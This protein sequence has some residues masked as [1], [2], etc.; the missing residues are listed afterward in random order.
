MADAWCEDL[1]VPPGSL[2][3]ARLNGLRK[4]ALDE[5]SSWPGTTAMPAETLPYRRGE[6]E[7]GVEKPGKEAG[8]LTRTNLDDMKPMVRR[9]GTDIEFTPSF[10]TIFRLLWDLAPEDEGAHVMGALLFRMAFMLDHSS[11][12]PLIRFQ[13]SERAIEKLDL[14]IPPIEATAL[15]GALP[16]SVFL[17]LLEVLALNEDV[18]FRGHSG[19]GRGVGRRNNLLTCVNVI[20]W[21]LTG[22][23]PMVAGGRLVRGV[24][25]IP[26][27]A[28]REVFPCLRPA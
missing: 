26:Q 5:A 9:K 12:L 6:Y 20:A 14:E 2:G 18:K 25:P 10:S 8:W 16:P 23:H 17:F 24:A 4:V 22:V 3:G 11:Q 13:P 19:W 28:A 27:R 21:K 1:R 15:E 7:I